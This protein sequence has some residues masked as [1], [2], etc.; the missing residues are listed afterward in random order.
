MWCSLP[1]NFVNLRN[2]LIALIGDLRRLLPLERSGKTREACDDGAWTI[3]SLFERLKGQ[4]MREM[5]ETQA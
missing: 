1:D 3:G 5:P 2:D 4:K